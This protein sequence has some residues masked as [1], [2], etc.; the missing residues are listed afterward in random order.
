MSD[1]GY[2]TSDLKGAGYVTSNRVYIRLY[3]KAIERFVSAKR[4]SRQINS[5]NSSI[6]DSDDDSDGNYVDDAVK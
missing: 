1:M 2:S 3:N 6:S 5:N 4:P